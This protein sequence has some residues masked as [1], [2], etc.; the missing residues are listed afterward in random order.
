MRRKGKQ[1][2][3]EQ[4]GDEDEREKT[5][6]P[7]YLPATKPERRRREDEEEKIERG[8]DPRRRTERERKDI[9]RRNTTDEPP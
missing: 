1:E 7:F 8:I 6:Y 9:D 3:D 4:K 2:K 5:R